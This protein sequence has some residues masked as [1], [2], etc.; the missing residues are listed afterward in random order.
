MKAAVYYGQGDVRLEERPIPKAGPGQLVVKI[1]YCGVCG[2][3]V[4]AYHLGGRPAMV[5]GHENVGTV[6]EIGTGV[7]GFSPGDRLLCGPPAYC[8][9][10][11][12]PCKSGRANIC[13]HGFARTAG[14][15]GIDGGYE[16]YMLI[17]DPAHTVLVK[18][19]EG[20]D[21][22]D[23]VLF[24]IICVS[25][26]ALRRSNFKF[27]DTVAVSGGGPI[28]LAAIQLAKAAG[29]RTIVAIDNKSA[30]RPIMEQYGADVCIGLD[31]CADLDA[32]LAGAFGADG[33]ADVTFECAGTEQS[34]E[35]CIFKAAKPGGQ[36]L[37]VGCLGKP[38]EN[39][40]LAAM[41]PREVDL[42][43][44][45]VY[46]PEEVQVYLDLLLAR[47]ISFPGMVTDIIGL[48][49]LVEKGL[50]RKD[51]KGMIKVLCQPDRAAA[52][53]GEREGSD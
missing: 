47:K 28:G 14:I 16:E 38:A 5:L 20:V 52:D 48:D 9:E 22:K 1:D 33:G 35:N 34:L 25:L 17:R 45:F 8:A 3:D 49:E 26:H 36:V 32:A 6:H 53:E 27:G 30:R 43:S 11:C 51:R 41:M 39:L 40:V 15:G 24:D 18:I 4:E 29:A 31:D 46:T 7:E 12:V 21:E 50:D 2:S 44:S 37:L 10:G 13:T 23:A 19:P 42:I